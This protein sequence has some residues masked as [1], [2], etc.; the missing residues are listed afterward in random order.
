MGGMRGSAAQQTG[1]GKTSP[2]PVDTANPEASTLLAT[3]AY[4]AMLGIQQSALEAQTEI[5]ERQLEIADRAQQI[6]DDQ[7]ANYKEIYLP[8]ERQWVSEAT[9]G[10]PEQPYV[11]RASADVNQTFSQARTQ[12]AR[13]LTRFGIDPGDPRYAAIM[14]DIDVARSAAD[15]GARMN[16]RLTIN[17]V[18]Y[19][20]LSDVS[21]TGRGIPTEAAS[22]LSSASN[23]VGA[24]GG[25]L[26][27]GFNGLTNA[28]NQLGSY[29]SSTY[30]NAQNRAANLTSEKT[31]ADAQESA[32]AWSG[33]GSIAG[34]GLGIAALAGM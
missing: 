7:Y 23:S 18:N 12:A 22:T 15:A 5:S 13:E 29:Y 10:I 3:Q 19:Q 17:D 27:S 11:D 9:K 20:R 6:A 8:A 31:R 2:T 34:A 16:T 33:I 14:Q 32:S 30:Q 1:S 21:K 28:Y 4:M 26:A 25:A 24:A